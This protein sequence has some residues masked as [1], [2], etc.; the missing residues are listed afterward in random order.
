MKK[1]SRPGGTTKPAQKR[2]AQKKLV[3]KSAKPKKAQ[4]G[5]RLAEVVTQ[6]ALSAEKLAQA[7]DQLAEATA[8]LTIIAEGRH[9]THETPDPSLADSTTSRHE[10]EATDETDGK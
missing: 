3:T 8:R 10:S 6:L 4:D 9:E 5:A 2:P 7:A 1:A